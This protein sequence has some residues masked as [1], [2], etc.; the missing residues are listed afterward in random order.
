MTRILDLELSGLR[1]PTGRG[2]P[3]RNRV[4]QAA[5]HDAAFLARYDDRTLIYDCFEAAEG[6]TFL[7]PPLLN[8]KPLLA[9]AEIRV[10]GHPAAIREIR[11][12]SRCSVVVLTVATGGTVTVGHRTS[13]PTWRSDAITRRPSR[14]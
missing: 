9:E 10:D 2:L 6:I 5:F 4:G 7:C 1:L 13:A 14:G 11:D 8:L 12:L 3:A